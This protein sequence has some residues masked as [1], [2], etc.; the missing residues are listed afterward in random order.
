[1]TVLMTKRK[2]DAIASIERDR[3]LISDQTA[4]LRYREA[5]PEERPLTDKERRAMDEVRD[6]APHLR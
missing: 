1:M 5:T 3:H 2:A 4:D 6:R